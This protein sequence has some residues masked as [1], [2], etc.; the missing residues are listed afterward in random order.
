M[1]RR[2]EFLP[3]SRSDGGSMIPAKAQTTSIIGIV[4]VITKMEIAVAPRGPTAPENFPA[5]FVK[6]EH[7]PLQR[8]FCSAFSMAKYE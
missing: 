1:V 2:K 5:A 4:M 8:K 7:M 3:S 6:A